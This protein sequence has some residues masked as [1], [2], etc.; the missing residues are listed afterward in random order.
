[1]V[2]AKIFNTVLISSLAVQAA[3]NPSGAVPRPG[4]RWNPTPIDNPMRLH[5]ITAG[6]TYL[7]VRE[8]RAGVTAMGIP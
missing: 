8:S 4:A 6:I 2:N 7:E 1:M 3:A 5:P